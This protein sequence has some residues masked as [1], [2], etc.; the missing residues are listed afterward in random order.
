MGWAYSQGA[1]PRTLIFSGRDFIRGELTASDRHDDTW[2]FVAEEIHRSPGGLTVGVQDW[3]GFALNSGTRRCAHRG[4]AG[5]ADIRK[6]HPCATAAPHPDML[7]TAQSLASD[8]S[9]KKPHMHISMGASSR[10]LRYLRMSAVLQWDNR[11][12]SSRLY[13]YIIWQY[14]WSEQH[15]VC[16]LQEYPAL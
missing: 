11:E 12:W 8:S 6:T 4:E 2:R 14:G 13:W 7:L 5:F 3:S 9:Y 10:L 1:E 15:S 16:R